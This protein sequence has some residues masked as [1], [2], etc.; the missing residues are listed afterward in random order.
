MPVKKKTYDIKSRI[1]DSLE[2]RVEKVGTG[3]KADILYR[4]TRGKDRRVAA[5]DTVVLFK[6]ELEELSGLLKEDFLKR[7]F[8]N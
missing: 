8:Q 1:G 7:E 5:P 2:V 3:E 6:A 4:I